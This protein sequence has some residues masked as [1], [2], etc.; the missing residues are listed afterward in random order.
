MVVML[1]GFEGSGFEVYVG[2]VKRA[3]RA[4]LTA[5]FA[6]AIPDNLTAVLVVQ[7]T[8]R[9][10][11]SKLLEERDQLAERVSPTQFFRLASDLT[12]RLTSYWYDFFDPATG[13]PLINE[14]GPAIFSEL[15]FY[16][17]LLGWSFASNGGCGVVSHPSLGSKW[18]PCT[19]ITSASQATV[20]ANLRLLL[21]ASD[22]QCAIGGVHS[23]REA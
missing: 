22:L 10:V 19:I 11:C 2:P 3:V 17:R 1:V 7:A 23:T 13:F 14:P 20:L 21:P 5:V 6:G 8:S 15:D 16:Q 12:G 18:Y 4:D 9:S